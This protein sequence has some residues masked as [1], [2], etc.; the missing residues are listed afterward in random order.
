M[1]NIQ[2][3]NF[4]IHNHKGKLFHN[5]FCTISSLKTH[6]IEDI[7]LLTL[8]IWENNDRGPSQV[9]LF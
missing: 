7:Y 8:D 1:T 6:Q 4:E 5:Y 2:W 3:K 9:F